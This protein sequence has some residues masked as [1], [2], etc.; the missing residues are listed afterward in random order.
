MNVTEVCVFEFEGV[1]NGTIEVVQPETGPS[2]YDSTIPRSGAELQFLEQILS[3]Q[4]GVL[5]QIH[6]SPKK[7]YRSDG[8]SRDLQEYEKAFGQKTR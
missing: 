6:E 4:K 2:V 5:G 8:T 3:D 1:T 7:D